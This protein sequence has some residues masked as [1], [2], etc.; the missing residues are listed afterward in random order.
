[1]DGTG[2][3][4]VVPRTLDLLGQD[5]HDRQLDFWCHVEEEEF[6]EWK[7]NSF[8]TVG[9]NYAFLGCLESQIKGPQIYVSTASLI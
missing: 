4:D 3:N 5:A 1:M 9:K 7:P 6:V 8:A 2:R